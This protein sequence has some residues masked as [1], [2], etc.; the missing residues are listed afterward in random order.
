ML[1]VA[2]QLVPLTVLLWRAVASKLLPTPA[3]FHYVF[4]LR[5]LSRVRLFV[6]VFPVRGSV[7]SVFPVSVFP[8]RLFQG[9]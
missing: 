6:R 3:R 7:M 9:G 8:V 2:R 5:D 4:N 1:D